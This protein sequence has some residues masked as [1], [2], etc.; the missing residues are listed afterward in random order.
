VAFASA[1]AVQA[2]VQGQQPSAAS[3]WVLNFSNLP[4][5][6][7]RTGVVFY[8]VPRHIVH[9]LGDYPLSSFGLAQQTATA[10][11]SIIHSKLLLLEGLG[12]SN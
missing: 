9:A 6:I 5:E 10:Q 2:M 8:V 12:V 11:Y 3:P 7:P 4:S 1:S